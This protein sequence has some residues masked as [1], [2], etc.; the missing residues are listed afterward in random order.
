MGR[1]H[2]SFQINVTERAARSPILTRIRLTPDLPASQGKPTRSCPPH[3]TFSASLLG[4]GAAAAADDPHVATIFFARFPHYRLAARRLQRG[5][6]W[7][8]AET[9]LE[10]FYPREPIFEMVRS[11]VSPKK[12]V[13]M[14]SVHPPFDT[15]IFWK[16]ARTLADAGY[17]AVIVAG[18]SHEE[19]VHRVRIRPVVAESRRHR[20]MTRQVL[21][22]LRAAM[23]ERAD[24][25]HIHDPELIPIGLFLRL[26]GRRVI[27]DIH[28]SVP[29]QILS[30]PWIPVMLRRFVSYIVGLAEDIGARTFNAC[31][32][33]TPAI[34]CRFPSAKTQTIQNFPLLGEL[35]SHNAVAYQ[36]RAPCFVYVGHIGA[37]RGIREM[38]RAMGHLPDKCHATLY[39]AGRSVDAV[40]DVECP[41]ISG[42]EKVNSLGW[43]SR[44][45]VA[46]LLGKARAGLV[47]LH[48]IMNY[49]DAYPVKLFEYMAAG[50]PVIASDFPLWRQIVEDAGC[51]ILVDPLDAESISEAMTW[52][53]NNPEE[54]EAMG[55]RGKRAVETLYNWNTEARKLLALY[56]RVLDGDA[57][58]V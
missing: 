46:D 48:P 26:F 24:I 11:P 41:M 8:A 21:S 34:A 9:S 1:R 36:L 57:A 54:A 56:Q 32:A 39:V 35:E 7:S 52:I 37:D 15:R 45:E 5:P 58:V 13:H 27:Y 31:V 47:L 17:A 30:K 53:L 33:A 3:P 44:S 50:V 28:E 42:R 6:L 38:V 12:A 23:E 19:T 2:S 55:R 20:R 4:K 16:E 49:V 25:Y 14:T 18:H 43:Q 40:F 51:G 22:V 10:N 29:Q